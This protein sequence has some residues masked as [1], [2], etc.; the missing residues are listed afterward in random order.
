[1]AENSDE[2][3]SIQLEFGTPNNFETELILNTPPKF[4]NRNT[5]GDIQL[6]GI[7]AFLKGIGYPLENA[8]VYYFSNIG[9]IHVYCGNDPLPSTT[10]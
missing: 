6:S 2:N 5:A 10:Y 7:L 1:M 8:M 3:L 4:V 9:D